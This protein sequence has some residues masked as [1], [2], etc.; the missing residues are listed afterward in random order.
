VSPFGL[1]AFADTSA[2]PSNFEKSFKKQN[3]AK[4]L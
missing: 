4:D 2:K 3:Q 1:S